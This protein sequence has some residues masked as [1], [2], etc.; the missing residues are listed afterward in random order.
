MSHLISE[1]HVLLHPLLILHPVL[2]ATIG[3]NS[4]WLL[5]VVELVVALV[6]HSASYLLG[7]TP[8]APP[9]I[10]LVVPN[11]SVLVLVVA[12]LKA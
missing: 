12:P 2:L 10:A 7:P 11:V 4:C 6:P 5:S 1:H 3:P 9:P 8:A